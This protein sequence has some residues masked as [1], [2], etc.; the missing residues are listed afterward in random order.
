MDINI[1][2]QETFKSFYSKHLSSVSQYKICMPWYDFLVS[3][4]ILH[5]Q[6]IWGG[7]K[8]VIMHE[9]WYPKRWFQR[10][11]A[12]PTHNESQTPTW[13][14][15]GSIPFSDLSAIISFCQTNLLIQA[16]TLSEKFKM[17]KCGKKN[18]MEIVAAIIIATQAT[19]MSLPMPK[20]VKIWM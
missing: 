14:K 11:R 15:W 20:C 7:G 18:I 19:A 6:V 16:A 3:V 8:M 10:L 17:K 5:Y 12:F 2:N 4:Q 13:K 9:S 1:T